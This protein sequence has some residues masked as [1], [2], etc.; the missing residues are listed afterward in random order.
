MKTT[1][2]LLCAVLG[3]VSCSPTSPSGIP[4]AYDEVIQREW[5]LA[6]GLLKSAHVPRLNL[7]KPQLCNWVPHDGPIRT[8][9]QGEV[10]WAN[11]DFNPN[12]FTI[13]WNTQTPQVLRHEAGHAIL[14]FLDHRCWACW[15]LDGTKIS[16][17]P[18][19][20]ETS[21]T[22]AYCRSLL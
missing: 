4:V 2:V 8:T 13:R 15:S 22:G 17:H 20:C 6:L 1:P 21:S 16:P 3:A 9:W 5:A 14:R 7:V 10:A 18:G 19:A 11:G 12:T